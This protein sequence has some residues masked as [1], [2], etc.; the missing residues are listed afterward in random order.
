MCLK[1]DANY[2]LTEIFFGNRDPVIVVD[3]GQK[4]FHVRKMLIYITADLE[5]RSFRSTSLI[6]YIVI[7]PAG[8]WAVKHFGAA[9]G[10]TIS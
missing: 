2:L 9:M 5:P 8:R 10:T 7:M 1:S 4:K 6:A 3:L